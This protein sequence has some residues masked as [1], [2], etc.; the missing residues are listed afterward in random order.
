M[1]SKAQWQRLSDA[2]HHPLNHLA[3]CTHATLHY[4]AVLY[5]TVPEVLPLVTLEHVVVAPLLYPPRIRAVRLWY[6][7][8]YGKM[9][10]VDIK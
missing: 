5:I 1:P 10:A 8:I 3:T 9:I 6:Y 2:L 7:G 4:T